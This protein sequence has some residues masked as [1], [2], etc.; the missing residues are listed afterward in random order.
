MKKWET[1]G[2]GWVGMEYLGSCQITRRELMNIRI[3]LINHSSFVGTVIS[4]TIGTIACQLQL[5][6]KFLARTQR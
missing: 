2:T 6:A 5:L 4:M 1:E 3:K